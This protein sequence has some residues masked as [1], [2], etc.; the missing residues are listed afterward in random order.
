MRINENSASLNKF[1]EF[2]QTEVLSGNEDAVVRMDEGGKVG[3]AQ[4]GD[5]K[6]DRSYA[7]LSRA[8]VAK[9][10]N[11]ETRE[12]FA[13][14]IAK[15]F[16]KESYPNGI[17]ESVKRLTTGFEDGGNSPLTARCI[18]V[19]VNEVQR[20]RSELES[21]PRKPFEEEPSELELFKQAPS[22]EETSE[23][24]LF[25]QEPSKQAQSVQEPGPSL[26]L[27]NNKGVID[28]NRFIDPKHDSF[29]TGELYNGRVEQLAKS[30]V[31]KSTTANTYDISQTVCL[32]EDR[33]S[34]YRFSRFRQNGGGAYHCFFLSALHHMGLVDSDANA[35]ALREL[36]RATVLEL[37]EQVRAGK[38]AVSKED[39]AGEDNY[40][41]FSKDGRELYLSHLFEELD[42][43]LSFDSGAKADMSLSAVLA[44]HLQRPVIVFTSTTDEAGPY[45]VTT[46]D[47]DIFTGEALD[48]KP[49]YIWYQKDIHFEAME[50][51]EQDFEEKLP[52]IDL[53]TPFKALVSDFADEET[54]KGLLGKFKNVLASTSND[55]KRTREMRGVAILE[56]L[57]DPSRA[58]LKQEVQKKLSASIEKY[59]D[60]TDKARHLADAE[61][62]KVALK[63]A[64][65]DYDNR[66]DAIFKD[67]LAQAEC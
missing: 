47:R 66:L 17:P 1:V 41:M 50:P 12:A 4:V 35:A 59:H 28:H 57:L 56:W 31:G 13:R 58:G 3:A 27:S 21:F 20:L 15:L 7:L 65:T 61:N 51:L 42:R 44:H 38:S 40:K 60:D 30:L 10:S 36:F 26:G 11:A 52:P 62:L 39:F 14:E 23:L 54:T 45:G 48:Q 33:D 19:V 49:V 9:V 63:A 18:I 5:R 25:K 64:E 2:A 16:P 43:S 32:D 24:E 53:E 55:G 29:L 34:Q 37:Q 67:L 46:F 6:H 22:E 8:S